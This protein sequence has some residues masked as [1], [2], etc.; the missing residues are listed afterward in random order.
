MDVAAGDLRDRLDY[1]LDHVRNGGE[2]VVTEQGVP[3][4]RLAGLDDAASRI[5]SLA[6]RGVVSRPARSGKPKAAGCALPIPL[7][8]VSERIAEQRR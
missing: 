3:V 8:P 1:W 6:A 5:A 4:A 7:R 2:I